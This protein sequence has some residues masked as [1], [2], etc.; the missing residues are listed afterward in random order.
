MLV[1]ISGIYFI[2]QNFNKCIIYR[3]FPDQLKKADVS[4]AFKKGNHNDKTNYRAVGVL[5]SLSK[6]YERLIY[7]QINQMTENALSIFHCG[8][9]KKI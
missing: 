5:P 3:K 2:L 9:R 6:I 8:F 4:S 1:F 7:N